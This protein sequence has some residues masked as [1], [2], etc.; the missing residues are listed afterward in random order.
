[1]HQVCL[2]TKETY[3]LLL[4]ILKSVGFVERPNNI[5]SIYI[6]DYNYSAVKQAYDWINRFQNNI[7]NPA[8]VSVGEEL[9]FDSSTWV[10]DLDWVKD[11]ERH[12]DSEIESNSLLSKMDKKLDK[13]L[14]IL[15]E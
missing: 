15:Q 9:N 4:Y 12:K 1:M 10:K 6:T 7:F 5:Y 3:K 2:N 14:N 8:L 13:I 11:I